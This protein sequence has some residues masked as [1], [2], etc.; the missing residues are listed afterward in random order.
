MAAEFR[1]PANLAAGGGG[2]TSDTQ[3]LLDS[4]RQLVA[5][6]AL[7]ADPVQEQ[8]A[9]KL[10]EIAE[11]LADSGGNGG[12]AGFFQRRKSAPKGLY[13]WGDVGRGKTL[14]MDLFF[15]QV[16]IAAKRRVHF[17]EFMDEMHS[18]IAEFRKTER[19]EGD[20]D[21]IAAVVKPVI[22]DVRLLCFDEFHVTDI[23]NAMLLGRLFEKLFGAGLVMV[24]TS[25]VP[26]DGLY[27][28][29]L[30][31]Q[32]F[33][34]FIALLKSRCDVM[35]L[36]AA[37]DYR[38]E[39]LSSQPVFQFGGP[40]EVKPATDRLWANLTGGQVTHSDEVKSLGR[41][42]PVPET[43]MGAARF[44]F[45]ALC[46]K[47]LGARDYLAISHQFHTLMI[48]NVPQ[49]DRSGSNSA[50]RFIQLIDT[51]YDRGVKLAASFAVPLDELSKDKDTAFEMQRCV[52]RLQEMQSDGY[53]G[54]GLSG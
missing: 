9:Q 41:K 54:G 10:N 13:L 7:T 48:D 23:T 2:L 21:P 39:K 33:T 49:F 4:Y 18:A 30:N 3:S 36:G 45:S 19:G 46:D 5:D 37:R 20:A 8:A 25:N 14:L 34:P 16:P 51:L 42:I 26:P 44:S 24:A 15:E 53:L 22:R 11:G 1:W 35:E 12:L 32:L 38:L 43:A 40:D 17:H 29:G 28:N 31:R 50:R 6:G 27:K 47:P 52:S